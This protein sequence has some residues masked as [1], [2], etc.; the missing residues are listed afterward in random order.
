MLRLCSRAAPLRAIDSAC[1]WMY[2]QHTH[3]CVDQRFL[4]R[5]GGSPSS[6]HACDGV[7]HPGVYCTFACQSVTRLCLVATCLCPDSSARRGCVMEV[8]AQ[9]Q[10]CQR[11][12]SGFDA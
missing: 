2:V 1:V 8:G 4:E 3:T 6:A 11:W 10:F 12:G 5:V 7:H 9:M